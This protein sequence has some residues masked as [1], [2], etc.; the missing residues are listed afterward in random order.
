MQIEVV[1]VKVEN[2]GKWRVA[3]VTFKANGKVDQK[4]IMSFTDAFKP[5]AE[6]KQGDLFNVKPVQNAKGYWDWTDVTP[7]G[8]ASPS[9]ATTAASN[10]RGTW[11]TP[12]ERAKRQVYIVRQSSVANAIEYLKGTMPKG[13]DATP[14]DV[15]EVARKFEA[16]VFD[17]DAGALTDE[18]QEAEVE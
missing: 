2:K 5:L 13:L 3:A 17:T 8:K 6:A 9:S 12:E 1:D 14:E 7:A 11:E 18:V 15:V 4:P 16:Y 10:T